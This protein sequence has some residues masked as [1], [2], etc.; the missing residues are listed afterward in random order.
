MH[1]KERLYAVLG[2][3]VGGILTMMLSSIFPLMAQRD[4][5][6]DI[7]CTRITVVDERG[8]PVVVLDDL[9]H[10]GGGIVRVR[11][12][13]GKVAVDIDSR[14]LGGNVAV[15]GNDGVAKV[16]LG[17]LEHGGTVGVAGKG[18][19]LAAFGVSEYGGYV[20]T[21]DKYG[22]VTGSIGSP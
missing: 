13:D 14:K 9:A 12:N 1:S 16:F 17:I 7:T 10:G 4:G 8:K 3:I 5:F 21:G 18:K 22:K 20:T 11:G 19:S 15:H 2:G 6:G